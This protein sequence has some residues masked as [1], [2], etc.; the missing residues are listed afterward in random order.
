MGKSGQAACVQPIYQCLRLCRGSMRY[1]ALTKRQQ[2]MIIK[3]H[4]GP[5]VRHR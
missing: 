1:E 3:K 2:A 4:Q 5:S